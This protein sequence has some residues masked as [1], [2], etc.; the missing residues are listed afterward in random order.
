MAARVEDLEAQEED[1]KE[2][3]VALKD[4]IKEVQA[5]QKTKR[6]EASSMLRSTSQIEKQL[7]T[8]RQNLENQVQF[9]AVLFGCR[10]S[11]DRKKRN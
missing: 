3:L 7:D 6:T 8:L 11:V 5:V 9:R 2:R 1:A 4:R 10:G